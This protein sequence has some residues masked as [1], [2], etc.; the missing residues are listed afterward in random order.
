MPILNPFILIPLL[1]FLVL[2]AGTLVWIAVLGIGIWKKK[3]W[4]K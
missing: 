3:R 4:A 1:L 2:G